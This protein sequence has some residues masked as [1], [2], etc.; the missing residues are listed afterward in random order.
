MFKGNGGG[1]GTP[2]ED[3]WNDPAQL[4]KYDA[5]LLS[6]EGEEH[7][8]T[9]GGNA[10]NARGSMYEY[11]NAG[12]RVFAT[13]FHYTWFKNSPHDEF[14]QVAE[15]GDSASATDYEIDQTFPKGAKFAE[16]LQMVGASKTAG[17]IHLEN[18]ANSVKAAKGAATAWI[19]APTGDA[20]YP[21]FNTPMSAPADKQCGR[22][23]FSDVHL[24]DISGT[25]SIRDCGITS[26]S[27]NNQQ[28]AIEFL[29]F[30][31]T[32]CVTDDRLPPPP[33]K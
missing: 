4:R 15:W 14:R 17:T 23:V 1:M 31:L 33:L 32:A 25:T 24:T 13:H 2:A 20:K 19:K 27:L 8:E 6:C 16:W 29:F 26:G 10:P 22:A 9:K 21:S 11:L 30:D 28:K 3:F 7:N 18:V 5:V 12:G